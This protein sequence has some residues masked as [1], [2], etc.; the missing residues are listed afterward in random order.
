VAVTAKAKI[1]SPLD[2]LQIKNKKNNLEKTP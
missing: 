1:T 2:N